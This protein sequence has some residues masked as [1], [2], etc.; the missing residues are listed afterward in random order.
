MKKRRK[1]LGIFDL[2]I[3]LNEL[4]PISHFIAVKKTPLAVH[5]AR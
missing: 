5:D 1:E 4:F 3:Q 2:G